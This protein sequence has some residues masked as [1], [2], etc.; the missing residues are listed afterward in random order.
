VQ[1]NKF[2]S[3]AAF[4]AAGLLLTSAA[5]PFD[6]GN[7]MN[8]SKWMGGNKDHDDYDDYDRGYGY[9]GYPGYG[10]GGYP[11]YGWGGYPGYGGY[12]YGYGGYPGYTIGTTGAASGT[13]SGTP[14]P[15]LPE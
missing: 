8:P 4:V 6:M 9:R 3:R 2:I 1:Y 11:G 15:K 14:A 12:G 5:Y 10:W 13:G 7:M